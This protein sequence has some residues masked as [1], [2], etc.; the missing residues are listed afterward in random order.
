MGTRQ[1][2]K[3]SSITAS[4]FTAHVLGTGSLSSLSSRLLYSTNTTT[5]K[6]KSN[7]GADTG[8]SEI[9]LGQGFPWQ[10]V[11]NVGTIPGQRRFTKT[12]R[13]KT[14]MR[15]SVR[16]AQ[17]SCPTKIPITLGSECNKTVRGMRIHLKKEYLRVWA[18]TTCSCL[19]GS[20][21]ESYFICARS[22]IDFRCLRFGLQGNKKSVIRFEWAY[23]TFWNVRKILACSFF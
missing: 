18:K 13:T 8:T 4:T 22:A 5:H 10:E 2:H 15:N 7:R 19:S 9:S 21:L 20:H 16:F 17:N 11:L 14:K 3:L 12:A 23:F 1:K 6:A